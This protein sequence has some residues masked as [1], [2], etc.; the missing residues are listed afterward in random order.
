MHGIIIGDRRLVLAKKSYYVDEGNRLMCEVAWGKNK[1]SRRQEGLM[2]DSF[3]G[4]IVK[5]KN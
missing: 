4:K 1:Q 5:V 2:N 3:S